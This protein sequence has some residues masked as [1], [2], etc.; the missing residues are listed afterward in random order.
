MPANRNVVITGAGIVCSIGN[1]FGPFRDSLFSGVSGIRALAG[2]I[3]TMDSVGFGGQLVG[4]DGRDHVRPRKALKVMSLEIQTAYAASMMALEMSGLDIQSTPPDRIATIFGSEMMSGEPE[5]LVDAMIDC[6]ILDGDLNA[7]DFGDSAIR[8]MFPLWM[9]KYLPNMA[10]CHVGIALGALG[11]NN[12]LVLGDT[13]ATAALIES[14]CVLQRGLADCVL[15]GTAG[16]RLS[17]TRLMYRS[18]FGVPTRRNPVGASSRPMAVDRDG[19]VGG[20]GAGCFVLEGADEAKS[21]GAKPLAQICGTAVRFAAADGQSGSTTQ[22]IT[23][24]A[25]AALASAGISPDEIGAIVSHSMGHSILDLSESQAIEQLVGSH[26]PVVAPI[27]SVG[28]T[29]AASGAMEIATALAIFSLGQVPATLN[30]S[31]KDPS[32]G[33]R[34]LTKNEPL[35]QEYVLVLTHTP[36]GHATAIVLQQPAS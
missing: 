36:Q 26:C 23:I 3:G 4:F 35:Q 20:E 30:A 17:P 6:G 5:E 24:A 8:K 22:A 15:S 21:R 25:S 7:A 12:S 32:F 14:E 31:A 10:A 2:P 29:G 33:A 19:I 11:P 28:H 9:L 1:G 16:T 18:G 27:A 13:S 34:L